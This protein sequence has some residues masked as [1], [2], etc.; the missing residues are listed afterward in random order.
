[1]NNYTTY[2]PFNPFN[3]LSQYIVLLIIV[4]FI[5]AIIAYLIIRS[6][7]EQKLEH[8]VITFLICLFI[9]FGF[10]VEL[11][12]NSA[13]D[14]TKRLLAELQNQKETFSLDQNENKPAI[15]KIPKYV[16][17]PKY[18]GFNLRGYSTYLRSINFENIKLVFK[19]DA[20]AKLGFVYDETIK[21]YPEVDEKIEVND[22]LILI[23]KTFS[24]EDW[25][26]YAKKK[27]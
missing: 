26:E 1:M 6:V 17:L 9:P 2:T 5:G 18:K 24:K 23:D 22:S 16:P 10:Y 27:K 15:P 21:K 11:I 25:Q 13:T 4:Y 12:R 20:Y 8:P 3:Y 7:C 19:N 14:N